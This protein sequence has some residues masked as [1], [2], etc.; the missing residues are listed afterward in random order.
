MKAR[1]MSVQQ[2][3]DWDQ[4]RQEIAREEQDYDIVLI[5]MRGSRS[6]SLRT[7]KLR[8]AAI[9]RRAI[10]SS[11]REDMGSDDPSLRAWAVY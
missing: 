5:A 3:I 1:D 2:Y 8:R 4:R 7:E 11:C 6:G 9:A 10:N